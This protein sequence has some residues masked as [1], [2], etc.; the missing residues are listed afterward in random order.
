VILRALCEL[1]V[2]EPELLGSADDFWG[3]LEAE[4]VQAAAPDGDR[5][6]R[7]RR[8]EGFAGVAGQLLSSGE[9]ALIVCA[10]VARRREALG[11]V[12]GRQVA[13]VVSWAALE[14]S[15]AL[16]SPFSHV[17][18]LD[19]PLTAAGEDLLRRLPGS[20]YAH[21]VWGEPELA[22]A[23]AVAQAELDLRPVLTALYRSLRDVGEASGEDLVALLRG[24]GRY[25][26]S[27]VLCGRLVRVLVELGLASYFEQRLSLVSGVR[28]DLEAAPTYQRC[29]QQ[30]G[31][32]RAYLASAMPASRMAA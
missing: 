24:D 1:E 13:P 18:A 10:D 30:L 2:G 3:A 16:A 27:D 26:R 17:V 20:G 11:R 25:P 29:Q 8:G 23:L 15:P 21:L 19:P 22:F 12:L 14:A 5:E 4:P 32:A 31:V 7:D 6:L 28:G 9:P